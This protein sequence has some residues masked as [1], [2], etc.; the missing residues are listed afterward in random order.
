VIRRIKE[1]LVEARTERRDYRG[2]AL[3]MYIDSKPLDTAQLWPKLYAALDLIGEYTPVW[4]RRMQQMRNSVNIRSI[5]GT[6][7]RLINGN[8]TLLDPYLLADFLPAQIAS[9]IVHE[10]T[11]ARLRYYRIPFTA[12]KLAREERVCRRSELRFGRAIEGGGVEGARAVVE[13]AEMA[14]ASRDEDVGVAVNWQ[15]LNALAAIARIQESPYP[16]WLKRIIARRQG[17]LD[18]PQGQA[19]FTRARD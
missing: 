12:Q 11:H 18:T 7:A 2:I 8:E 17:V 10:A 6:R 16:K 14:L 13:R 3:S 19:A 5:P 15:E 9:S 1:K 4:L